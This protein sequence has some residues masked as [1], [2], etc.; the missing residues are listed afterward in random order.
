M[1]DDGRTEP[2]CCVAADGAYGLYPRAG[3]GCLRGD[4]DA[5]D[6]AGEACALK[7]F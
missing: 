7:L 4:V 1:A 2:F 5:K 6:E 3:G